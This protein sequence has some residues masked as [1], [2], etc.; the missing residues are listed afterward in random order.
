MVAQILKRERTEEFR[1]K[2]PHSNK[3]EAASFTR[4]SVTVFGQNANYFNKAN[5]H[6]S[7]LSSVLKKKPQ[8]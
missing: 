8:K 5:Q 4:Y 6:Y 2:K 7:L 3:L 1:F